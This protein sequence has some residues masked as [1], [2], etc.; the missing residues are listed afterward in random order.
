MRHGGAEPDDHTEN[1][2]YEKDRGERARNVKPG[3]QAHPRLEE[4]V[5][6]E[7]QCDR[8][9]DVGGCVGNDQKSYQQNTNLHD[10]FWAGICAIR[11]K[12]LRHVEGFSGSRRDFNSGEIVQFMCPPS[13]F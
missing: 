11:Q 6:D 5:Q 10:R 9:N 12:L 4:K 3:Q 7:G 1:S 13:A 2:K 8:Q